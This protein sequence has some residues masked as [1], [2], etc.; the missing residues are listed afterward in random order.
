MSGKTMRV[1]WYDPRTGRSIRIGH[2]GGADTR[3]GIV[4]PDGEDWVMVFDSV[5]E[6]EMP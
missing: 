3:F 2:V 1:H 6:F 5:E 4:C